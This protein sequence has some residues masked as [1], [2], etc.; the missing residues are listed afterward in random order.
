MRYLMTLHP[1]LIKVIWQ[2]FFEG[3]F[4]DNARIALSPFF[5]NAYP[6]LERI[7]HPDSSTSLNGL[8]A[9]S[10]V[11]NFEATRVLDRSRLDPYVLIW[12]SFPLAVIINAS[13]FIGGATSI[14]GKKVP[15]A[16]VVG[17]FALGVGVVVFA[18][19]CVCIFYLPRY[20]LPLLVTSIFAL[21][22]SI[23][24][25]SEVWIN[26]IG[27]LNRLRQVTDKTDIPVHGN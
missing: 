26:R 11:N 9:L 1:I 23:T 27:S 10:S 18:A 20:S 24:S 7:R 15:P 12:H 19:N 8:E 6:A 13:F 4:V 17:L 14:L 22:T 3:I 25:F 21:L 5:A 2:D 16:S